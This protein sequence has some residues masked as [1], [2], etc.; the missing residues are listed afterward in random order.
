MTEPNIAEPLSARRLPRQIA[1]ATGRRRQRPVHRF[2]QVESFLCDDKTCDRPSQE[3]HG[4]KRVAS[5]TTREY[6][7]RM[8]FSFQ[9][10]RLYLER[11]PDEREPILRRLRKIEGQVRG[12]QQM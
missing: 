10:G 3:S 4:L 5:P 7:A 9:D 11:S 2:E 6:N 8:K 1:P 12:L